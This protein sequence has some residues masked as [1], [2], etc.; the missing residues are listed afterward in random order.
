MTLLCAH[1]FLFTMYQKL[2]SV[3]SGA[4]QITGLMA[5]MTEHVQ[6]HTD[7]TEEAI[8][9]SRAG[10]LASCLPTGGSPHTASLD[11]AAS[12]IASWRAAAGAPA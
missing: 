11:R 9:G 2:V 8:S 7:G 3:D 4:E 1:A 10:K 5:H 6:L 12:W